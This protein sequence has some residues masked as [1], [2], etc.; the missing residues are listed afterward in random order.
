MLIHHNPTKDFIIM[1]ST[2]RYVT[3]TNGASVMCSMLLNSW[4]DGAKY[5]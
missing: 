1:I 2:A 5:M 4:V 3:V